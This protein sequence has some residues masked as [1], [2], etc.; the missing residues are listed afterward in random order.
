ML[1][2]DFLKDLLPLRAVSGDVT[3]FAVPRRM[4]NFMAFVIALAKP[5]VQWF[6]L[7]SYVH[8]GGVSFFVDGEVSTCAGKEIFDRMFRTSVLFIVIKAY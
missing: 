4:L 8:M 2:N 6:L 3:Y 1:W 7:E 5:V